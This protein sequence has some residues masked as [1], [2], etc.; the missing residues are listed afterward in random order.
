MKNRTHLFRAPQGGGASV[1]LALW[2]VLGAG[3]ARA[4]GQQHGGA[5]PGT[6]WTGEAGITETVAHIMARQA[7]E[8]P[9]HEAR[10]SRPDHSFEHA[11]PLNPASP[12]VPCWPWTGQIPV[13]PPRG[14]TDNPQALGTNVL[15]VQMS[16]ASFFP[17]PDSMGDVGPS[18]IVVIVNGR[19]KTLSKATGAADGALNVTNEL[20]FQ[21]VRRSLLSDPQARYDPTSS[22]WFLTNIEIRDP[23]RILIAVSSGPVISSQT[24]FTFFQFQHDLV[25]PTPNSD[26]DNLADYPSLGVDANAVYIGD[27]VFDPTFFV[28][29]TGFVVRKS[30]VLG[31]GPIV[32][33]AFRQMAPATGQGIGSPR[34]VSNSDPAATEGYF[35]GNDMSSFGTLIVRRIMDPGGT[36]S[37]SG[38][39]VISVPATDYPISTPCLGSTAPLDGLDDRLFYARLYRNRLTGVSTLWTAHNIQVDSTGVASTFGGRNGSRWY[40]IENLATTPSL[41]QAGTLFDSSDTDPQSFWIP[42]IAMSGQGHAALG[43]SVAGPTRHAEVASAG[44]LSTDAL[45]TIQ[46]PSTVVT[47]DATYNNTT[48][49][50]QRW[51]DF[52]ATMVDPSDDQSIWTFQEYCN[53]TDSWG[54]RVARLLAPPPASPVTCSPNSLPQ[55][56]GPHDVVVTGASVAGSGFYDTE[57]GLNRLTAAFDGAGITVNSITFTSPTQIT[58]NVTLDSAATTGGRTLSVTNPDGQS[59]GS[60]VPIFTVLSVPCYANCDG[61]TATPVLNIIDF[62][63]FLQKFAAG[64]PYANCDQS[65]VPPVLNVVDFTCFL[66]KYAAGCP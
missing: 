18:Q 1:T 51:G 55:G 22:R 60:G 29:T 58:L 14:V 7:A 12:P 26:T 56:A 23:N 39:L 10:E 42:S 63:C 24:S 11:K 54:V 43:C 30:S 52:S 66:Q 25:G 44:R 59:A 16:E 5:T 3:T 50:P 49:P 15:G 38:D 40:E 35:I 37:I 6:P 48:S 65:T 19:I 2:L 9:P 20:F 8:G 13:G 47:T 57:P 4:I 46:A 61:S 45:G 27:N 17:P 32:V 36:P 31:A 28:G 53:A 33:T 34:G 21:S 62:T 41:R 64:D